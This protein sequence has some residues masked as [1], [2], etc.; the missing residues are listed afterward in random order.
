[1]F[2]PT[3]RLPRR[4]AAPAVALGALL[5]AATARAELIADFEA[6]VRAGHM[7][8][9]PSDTSTSHVEG[10]PSLT[11]HFGSPRLVWRARYLFNGA[12][13]FQ[14]DGSNAYANLLELNLAAQPTGRS[15]L[16]FAASASQ[17]STF[18][19]LSQRA[20]DAARPELRPAGDLSR[21]GATALQAF[22][23]EAAP[24]L[25]LGQ[26][27]S[28]A[29]D[30]P[31][32]ALSR[33][34]RQGTLSLSADRVYPRDSFGA[35]YTAR[36]AQLHP[37]LATDGSTV[38]TL[39]NSLQASWN[40]DL[41]QQWNGQITAGFEHVAGRDQSSLHPVASLTMR[42]LAGVWTGAALLRHGASANLE[43]G[44]MSLTDEVVLRASRIFE[45]LPQGNLSASAGYLRSG[46]LRAAGAAAGTGTAIS[47]DLGLTWTLWGPLQASMR[48][49][50]SYQPARGTS[51]AITTHILLG[52]VSYRYSTGEHT[53]TPVPTLG[54]RVDGGDAVRFPGEARPQ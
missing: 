24:G 36:L 8:S 17:G 48:Y 4:A 14:G 32:D 52:G 23:W 5:A 11:L 33:A 26:M 18:F 15:T 21:V 47:G 20:V 3:L 9:A 38:R 35:L 40:R 53:P 6:A 16:T 54:G 37:A 1:M 2:Q 51:D 34:N 27:L 7:R 42:Y 29:L 39:S 50:L 30:A 25:A 49:T 12:Y 22:S 13:T 46:P 45:F 31:Q 43:E 41:D 19:R 44:T 28:F 10:Q